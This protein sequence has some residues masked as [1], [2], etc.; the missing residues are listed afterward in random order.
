[1]KVLKKKLYFMKKA[2]F[3]IEMQIYRISAIYQYF[4]LQKQKKMILF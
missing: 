3:A 4:F 2:N 1:M